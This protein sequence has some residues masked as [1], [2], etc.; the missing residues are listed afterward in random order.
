MELVLKFTCCF[1]YDP[2]QAKDSSQKKQCKVGFI[3]FH[4]YEWFV[5]FFKLSLYFLLRFKSNLSH[6]LSRILS[7]M[8][9][10]NVLCGFYPI[11]WMEKKEIVRENFKISP[12]LIE[13]KIKIER[14]KPLETIF[15]SFF[16]HLNFQN[17][18]SSKSQRVS[19]IVKY[20]LAFLFNLMQ[21]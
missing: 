2:F 9:I 4:C 7:K 12:C 10:G 16:L 11:V 5:F 19:Q 3:V 13:E 18:F 20:L 17:F 8:S 15:S 1:S 14:K 21:N 6:I